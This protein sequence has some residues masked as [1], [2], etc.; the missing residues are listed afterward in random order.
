MRLSD[1][2]FSYT[3][4]ALTGDASCQPMLKVLGCTLLLA[5]AGTAVTGCSNEP[6]PPTGMQ[7]DVGPVT[8]PATPLPPPTAVLPNGQSITLELAI[9]PDRRNT[10]LMFRTKLAEDRGMLFVFERTVTQPFW[11]KN[12][13]IPLDFIFLDGSGTIT[14][15]I[16]NVP[17]CEVDPCPSYPPRNPYRAMLEVS[18]G[19]AAKHSLQPGQTL[20]LSRV[21]D[22]PVE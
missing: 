7:T 15:I 22:Y 16:D 4:S 8:P 12:T 10:G 2:I 13:F 1:W 3:C 19:V 11:M 6:P 17:P 20:E 5:I 14:E 9:S 18:A 21:P